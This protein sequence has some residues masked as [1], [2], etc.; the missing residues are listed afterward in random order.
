LSE[1]RRTG[2]AAE[3][4]EDKLAAV[5]GSDRAGRVDSQARPEADA[6]RDLFARYGDRIF[7]YCLGQL[8]SREEAEDATQT[9][10]MNA[11]RGLQR[12]VVPR[13]E[14]AWL[15]RIAQNVCL[16]RRRS[17]RR[18]GRIETPTNF[19]VLQDLAPAPERRSD[20]LIRLQ[21]VLAQM[22]PMQRRAIL[23]REWRGLSYR[24]IAAELRLSVA[25][26]ETLIFRAR[27]SLAAGLAAEP[28]V[29]KPRRTR[30]T[31]GVDASGLVAAVK[32]IFGGGTAVKVAVTVAAVATTAVASGDASSHRHRPV[33]LVPPRGAAPVADV[34]RLA[35]ASPAGAVRRPVAR[36]AERRTRPAIVSRRRV[37]DR[38]A[39]TLPPAPAPVFRH[40]NDEPAAAPSTDPAPPPVVAAQ[41]Q[42][43]TAPGASEPAPQPEAVTAPPKANDDQEHVSDEESPPAAVEPPGKTKPDP[44]QSAAS[45]GNEERGVATAPGQQDKAAKPEKSRKDGD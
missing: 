31:Y 36:H 34:H 6:T 3:R 21:D 39:T 42:M 10:F 11:F 28:V 32:A 12:G 23:M 22:P 17:A 29:A 18:R 19:T 25:A 35:P 30:R 8:D 37:H 38:G 7:G 5:P 43:Q 45:Q 20:E 40:D 14:D 2:G 44:S 9:T 1:R 15:F 41:P 13:V 27:R 16:S 26:V 24:E 4:E 33:P